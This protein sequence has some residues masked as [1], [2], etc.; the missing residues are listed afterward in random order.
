M[1]IMWA[2]PA[3]FAYAFA[4]FSMKKGLEAFVFRAGQKGAWLD[5]LIYVGGSGAIIVLTS[6]MILLE[7]HPF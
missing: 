1:K 5:I 3:L 4:T 7:R 6:T 2:F